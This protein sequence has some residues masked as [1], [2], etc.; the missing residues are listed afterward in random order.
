M[1]GIHT[2]YA[3]MFVIN[4]KARITKEVAGEVK[5]RYEIV[6]SFKNCYINRH[7]SFQLALNLPDIGFYT[8]V[9][10]LCVGALMF[11]IGFY[12]SCTNKWYK[13]KIEE[14]NLINQGKR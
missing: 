5:V 8:G 1:D 7:L 10:F 13:P 14:Q 11:A 4:S 3:P 9:G 2:F 6:F 12:L